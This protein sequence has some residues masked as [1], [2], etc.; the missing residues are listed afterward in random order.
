MK[1]NL[2]AMRLAHF[3]SV[4]VLVNTYVTASNPFL[5]WGNECIIKTGRWSLQI[6]TISIVFSAVFSVIFACCHPNLIEKLLF[7][8]AGILIMAL[9]AIWLA[10]FAIPKGITKRVG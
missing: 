7:N 4:V 1:Y 9:A 5:R 3:L 2:S 8:L 6:Y 10:N